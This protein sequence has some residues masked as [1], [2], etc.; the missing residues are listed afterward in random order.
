VNELVSLVAIGDIE[1]SGMYFG[2]YEKI[3]QEKLGPELVNARLS[4]QIKG[5]VRANNSELILDWLRNADITFGNLETTL[6]KSRPH[7]HPRPSYYRLRSDP[8]RAEDLKLLGIDVVS[9]ANN[10]LVDYDDEGI[11]DTIEALDSAGIKHVG[12]GMNL[13]E[14]LAPAIFEIEGEKLGFL[15][16][17][18]A[19]QKAAADDRAGVAA[20]RSKIVKEFDSLMLPTNYLP[21]YSVLPTIKEVPVK[22]DVQMMQKCIKDLK[23]KVGF[24]AVSIHWGPGIS[25]RASG[26]SGALIFEAAPTDCQRALGHAIVDAGADLVIGGHP[27]SAQG[28]E[29]YKNRQIFYSLANFAMQI[30]ADIARC[31]LFMQ[32]AYMVKVDIENNKASRVEILPTRTDETGFPMITEDYTNV[33]KHLEEVSAPLNVSVIP[34][35]QSAIIESIHK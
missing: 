17:A 12:G 18:T 30:E 13:K 20:I 23:K 11:I 32:E 7:Y 16:F 33:I 24:V 19:F 5:H 1:F 25:I 28:M 8:S 4:D 22:E 27:H 10:H 9:L 29:I 26:G 2:R 31:E 21:F 34:N 6:A 15:G 14:A 35:K 3:G